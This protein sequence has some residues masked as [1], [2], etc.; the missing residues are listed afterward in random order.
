MKKWSFILLAV[1]ILSSC[2][3][4]IKEENARLKAEL[5]SIRM[6][7]VDQDSTISDF[8]TTFQQVQDNLSSIREREESIR[9]V[10]EG[11][12]ENEGSTRDK[13]ISDIEAINSLIEKNKG[14]IDDLRR[15]LSSSRGENRK[16]LKMVENLNRQIE[17][18]N[19]QVAELYGQLEQANFKVSQLSS[20]VGL[21]TETGMAQKKVIEQQDSEL[22]T[23]YYTMGTYEELNE[24]GVVDK[25]G[26]FIG[27][28]RT[29]TLAKDFNTSYFTK[30]DIRNSTDLSF[31]GEYKKVEIIT[32]HSTESYVYEEDNEFKKA[33]KIT[34]PLEFWKNSKYLVI[35]LDK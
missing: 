12:L 26:G 15:K 21:L 18:K 22:N 9:E 25:E 32:N 4:E 33:L 5:D 27:I 20:K 16:Y 35:I 6:E 7:S 24:A 31:N 3:Q 23:A 19:E 29:E 11:G 13:L 17:L 14:A 28:G 34:N 10:S 30:I 2:N 1:T 8:M